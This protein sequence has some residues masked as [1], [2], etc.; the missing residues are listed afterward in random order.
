MPVLS[1]HLLAHYAQCTPVEARRVAGTLLP[2]LLYYDTTCPASYPDNARKLSDD[3][4]NAL[5]TVIANGK[6]A[7]D[8]I[9]LHDDLLAKFPQLG[10]L[11][12]A[13]G[14][15]SL[16]PAPHSAMS[17]AVASSRQMWQPCCYRVSASYDFIRSSSATGA[18]FR[19]YR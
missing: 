12:T 16:G 17:M 4:T 13:R 9:R 3:A 15:L 2:D 1:A 6:V 18:F 19:S 14:N 11:T 7:G 8:G 10:R 5:L